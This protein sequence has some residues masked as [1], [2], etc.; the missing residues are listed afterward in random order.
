MKS[1][2]G[3]NKRT[4]RAAAL[5]VLA[6]A[7]VTAGAASVAQQRAADTAAGPGPQLTSWF[8]DNSNRYARV[9]EQT[10]QSAVTTWPSRGLPWRGGGQSKPAYADIQQVS[11]SDDWV[12]IQGTG[13]ASHQMGPWYMGVNR[14]FDNWP[15]NQSYIRRFPRHPKPAE[16]K[17]TNGLGDLGVWVNGVALFNM[18]DGGH[19]DTA[20]GYEQMSPPRPG[21][22]DGAIW[23]RNAVPVE[24]PTFD[25]SNAHQP[26]MGTYHYHSNPLGL[27]Y[28]LSDNVRYEKP[29]DSYREDT[30]KPHHSP[31]L[32]WAYDGYP[33]YGPYGYADANTPGT[34][35]RMVSG[36]VPRDGGHKT[37]DL[38]KTGRHSLAK[39]AAELH[40]TSAAL[41]ASQYGPD[42]SARYPIGRYC[43]DYDYL[44]DL[45]FRRGTEFDLDQ[46]NG[47][48]CVTP[49]YPKGTYAYFVTLNADGSAA[50]PYVIGRQYYGVPTGGNVGAVPEVVKTF[51][52]DGA[53]TP[54]AIKT[55]PMPDGGKAIG[56][57]SVEGGHY[58]LEA[59]LDGATWKTVAAD[60]RS[61]GQRTS[62]EVPAGAPMAK[63]TQFRVALVT[64]DAYD[65]T[66]P[67]R[68]GPGGGPGGPGGRG[69]GGPGGPGGYGVPGGFGGPV[70][71]GGQGA[72][73]GPGGQGGPGGGFPSGTGGQG[74][75]EGGFPGGPGGGRGGRGGFP[76]GGP[77]GPGG[78][79]AGTL[80]LPAPA[81]AKRGASIT[82]KI[83]TGGIMPPP[84]F[85]QPSAVTIGAIRARK[86][87]WD[88]VMLTAEFAIPATA[89]TGKQDVTATFPGPP[90]LGIDVVF[91]AKA[92]F[93]VE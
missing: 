22:Q 8:L 43:E 67:R 48:F 9:V 19:Y 50:Y 57:T 85:V 56:W 76:G 45:G 39:W 49:E 93:T 58:R 44:G 1:F 26:P 4:L 92:A 27:R 89:T 82:L 47:R 33:I 38:A 12:Y 79:G 7:L 68:R 83:R 63:A 62:E 17:A 42:V 73:R 54:I 11:Y 84:E 6:A 14:I 52:T 69:F 15:S 30:S 5:G 31:I 41:A 29:A 13:L 75:P 51:R 10:G 81:A 78:M 25:K 20:T 88:G 91:R 65:D 80:T 24:G 61:Q 60:V 32:G 55:T 71:F 74:G 36:F 3:S 40:G 86:A 77:G 28:Q 59:T 53:A 2:Y 16:K 34:V 23:V 46:Y 37:V 35:R 90:E 87:T 18:L 70:G 21:G 64:L 72:R 66:P